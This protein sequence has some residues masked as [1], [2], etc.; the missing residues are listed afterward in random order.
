MESQKELQTAKFNLLA[1][2][3]RAEWTGACE[4]GGTRLSLSWYAIEQSPYV[5]QGF[6]VTVRGQTKLLGEG[7]PQGEQRQTPGPS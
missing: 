3:K 5:M 4:S 2:V 6:R 1:D 7:E